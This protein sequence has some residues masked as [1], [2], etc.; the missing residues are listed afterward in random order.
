MDCSV[1]DAFQSLSVLLICIVWWIV[2]RAL[3]NA[4]VGSILVKTD[5]Q[6]QVLP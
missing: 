5:L 6:E 1:G 4:V 3:S 2:T